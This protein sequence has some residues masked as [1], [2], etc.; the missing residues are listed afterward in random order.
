MTKCAQRNGFLTLFLCGGQAV[1]A[2]FKCGKM[3]CQEH[4][5]PSPAGTL[6]P[7]C[8]AVGLSEDEASRRGLDSSYQRNTYSGD[9]DTTTYGPGDYGS[10]DQPQGGGGEMG[11]GGASGEWG[12]ESDAGD[13]GDGSSGAAD[14]QDS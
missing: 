9:H 5:L 2:C 8:A 3:I 7:D 14:F 4:L 13:E 10:F 11:G 1:T 6:C 12:D